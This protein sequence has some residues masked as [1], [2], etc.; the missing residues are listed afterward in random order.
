MLMLKNNPE[1]I[2]RML[3]AHV[4]RGER[5]IDLLEKNMARSYALCPRLNIGACLVGTEQVHEI[6]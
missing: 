4:N 6:R 3:K 1:D 2:W 5:A